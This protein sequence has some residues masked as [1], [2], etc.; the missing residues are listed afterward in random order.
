MSDVQT[1]DASIT[2]VTDEIC[3]LSLN[4]FV[5]WISIGYTLL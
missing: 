2:K 4:P 3:F 5:A 1:D